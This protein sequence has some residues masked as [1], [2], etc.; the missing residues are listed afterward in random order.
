MRGAAGYAHPRYA[1]SLS[2][3]GRPRFLARSRGW[4][5]ERDIEGSPHRD[6]MWCYPLFACAD[7]SALRHDLEELRSELVT[8]AVVTDPFGRYDRTTLEDA[9]PDVV[10]PFKDHFVTD[11][12]RDPADFVSAHHR[13][14]SRKALA[15]L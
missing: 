6:A 15:E 14:Y 3:F 8:L 7:W 1:A 12:E 11:L 5:L 4:V 9:F 2:E 10:I 13:R